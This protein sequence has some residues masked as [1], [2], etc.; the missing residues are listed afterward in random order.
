MVEIAINGFG[1]PSAPERQPQ[2]P[3]VSFSFDEAGAVQPDGFDEIEIG[4]E[5]EVVV[6]GKVV[7]ASAPD[8]SEW[9]KS[10]EF[11]LKVDSCRIG[12]Y[13]GN[14]MKSMDEAVISARKFIE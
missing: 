1:Q 14:G 2:P 3:T 6:T 8:G 7:R 10:R 5:C 11:T 9:N 13:G 4:E 12:G